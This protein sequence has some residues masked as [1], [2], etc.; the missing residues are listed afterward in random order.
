MVVPILKHLAFVLAM[1]A[2]WV[3]YGCHNTGVMG[4]TLVVLGSLHVGVIAR[5]HWPTEKEG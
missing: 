1:A 4:T 5:E 3:W 2:C